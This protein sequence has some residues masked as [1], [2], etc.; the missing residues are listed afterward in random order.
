MCA[1]WKAVL[2]AKISIL[3]RKMNSYQNHFQESLNIPNMTNGT[4]NEMITYHVF[5]QEIY[6]EPYLIDCLSSD[7]RKHFSKLRLPNHNLNIET[8]RHTKPYSPV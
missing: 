2:S 3:K 1:V 8:G 4:G 7:Q 6:L 5:K